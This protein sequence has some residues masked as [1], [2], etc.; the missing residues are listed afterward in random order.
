MRAGTRGIS[1]LSV[2]AVLLT[3]T[4]CVNS[5]ETVDLVSFTNAHGAA[6]TALVVIAAYGSEYIASGDETESSID[7]EFPPEGKT[8]VREERQAF[9]DPEPDRRWG[10]TELIT[11]T[12]AHGRACTLVATTVGSGAVDESS[13]DCDYPPPE[14]RPGPSVRESPPDPDPDSDDDRIQLVVF[15]D[16]HGRSCTTATSKVG[17]TEEIDLTCAYPERAEEPADT[18][19]Q[20]TPAPR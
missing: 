17:P 7:C 20:E 11:L 15:T 13:I 19:P 14:R 4:S 10:W 3:A 2:S 12:D 9:P 8:P 1:V 5:A 6:C 18:T 16:A